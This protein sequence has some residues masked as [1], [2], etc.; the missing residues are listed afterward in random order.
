MVMPSMS[1]SKRYSD[2]RTRFQGS[3]LFQAAAW[4]TFA[5]VL[6]Q[7]IRI[8]GNLIMT[9]LLAPEMFGVMSMV[10]VIQIMLALFSDIGVNTVIIQSHRGDDPVLLNTAWSMESIRGGIIWLICLCA[11]GGLLLAQQMDW[12]PEGSAW[13]ASDLPYA[14]AVTTFAAVISGLQSTNMITAS[15]NLQ[16]EKVAI[17]ELMAQVGGLLCMI[18]I[19]LLTGSIWALVAGALV[20]SL[21]TSSVSHVWLPGISNRFGWDWDSFH[22]IYRS[23][24]WVLLSSVLFVLASNIDRLL[25][26]GFVSASVL[27]LY[28]IAL[29]LAL[30]INSIGQRLFSDVVLPALSE[31]ARDDR[32]GFRKALLRLRYPFDIGFLLASGLIFATGPVV[33][34]LLYDDRYLDAGFMLQILSISLVFTRYGIFNMAYVA[35]GHAQLMASVHVVK[36][37]SIFALLLLLYHMFGFTGALIAIAIHAA[38]SVLFMFWANHF[39]GLNDFKYEFLVLPVWVIGYG[40]GLAGLV[41]LRMLIPI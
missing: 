14:L 29:N 17:L 24:R 7:I 8:C 10:L 23:G 27:G 2:L 34:E 13:T 25:L 5:L 15:R 41:A 19:G 26:A 18:V 3:R 31:V 39:H 6:G 28:A 30:M 20:K 11:A 1:F 4:S 22:E 9:R 32:E 12:L 33:V 21:I 35:L 16:L 38:P 37:V 40:A 36:L